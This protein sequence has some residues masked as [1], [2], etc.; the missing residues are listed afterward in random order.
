MLTWKVLLLWHTAPAVAPVS[1]LYCHSLSVPI[2]RA[3]VANMQQKI[4]SLTVNFDNDSFVNYMLT[5][6][7]RFIIM[8]RFG[9]MGPHV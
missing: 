5:T 4:L 6:L 3:I 2:A 9:F 1:S 7:G 8:G